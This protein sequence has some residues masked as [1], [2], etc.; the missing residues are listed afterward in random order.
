MTSETSSVALS[1]LAGWRACP[2]EALVG[3]DGETRD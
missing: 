1:H 2:H 3:P